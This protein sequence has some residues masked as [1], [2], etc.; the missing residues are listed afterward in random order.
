MNNNWNLKKLEKQASG[1]QEFDDYVL[2]ISGI[3]KYQNLNVLDIGCSNGFKTKMLFDKYDNI[4]HINGIDIDDTAINEAKEEFKNN[5]RYNFEL[6]SID[7]LH[8]ENKY[9][10]IN[11]SYVLQHLENPEKILANL[12]KK[13][14]DRGIIIIKVPDDSFKF[15]YPDPEDLL[16][17]IFNLYE[18]QIMINQ[19]ITK[20]TDRYIGKKVYSYLN[21]NK[22]KN[23]KLFYSVSDTIGKTL[24]QKIQMFDSS[25]A[26]RSADNKNNI[27]DKIKNNKVLKSNLTKST[28]NKSTT[29]IVNK[30]II[31]VLKKVTKL[32]LV[33]RLFLA[34]KVV[35]PDVN[36][37]KRA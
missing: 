18:S 6:K 9:D 15:C 19:N 22:F 5:S 14:T 28:L 30:K 8:D 10:I 25:I 16:H 31:I 27:P 3:L 20:N 4:T 23:I 24:E 36:A 21:N 34:N 33:L 32:L 2:N 13:L 11:L 7:D 17:K 29:T 35:I 12:K 26:Y 1:N 37:A